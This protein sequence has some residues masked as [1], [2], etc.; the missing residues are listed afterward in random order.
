M[1]HLRHARQIAASMCVRRARESETLMIVFYIALDVRLSS[2]LQ[3]I[4]IAI[5]A[6][7]RRAVVS[8][9][10]ACGI[11]TIQ[12]TVRCVRRVCSRSQAWNTVTARSSSCR[13]NAD[14]HC[15]SLSWR[16]VRKTILQVVAAGSCA[17]VQKAT[18]NVELAS[19]HSRFSWSP[20][21]GNSFITRS[22]GRY[23][24]TACEQYACDRQPMSLIEEITAHA[25][26]RNGQTLSLH[27]M[28]SAPGGTIQVTQQITRVVEPTHI[29]AQAGHDAL[30]TA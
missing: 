12:M 7:G 26:R 9:S 16:H 13:H 23:I 10:S 24:L 17:H 27:S 1:L 11:H 30:I 2:T 28:W 4:S 14:R 15:Q 8:S 29:N 25:E 19:I 5:D 6:G 20:V 22:R 18:D 3:P 21:S